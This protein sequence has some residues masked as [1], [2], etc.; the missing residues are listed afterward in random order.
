MPNG[1]EEKAV[2]ECPDCERPTDEDGASTEGCCYGADFC[3]T[4]GGSSCDWS[5]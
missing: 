2:G 1:S 4:C 3:E 5:C